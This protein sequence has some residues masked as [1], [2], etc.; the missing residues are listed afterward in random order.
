MP[1]D[2]E[3]CLLLRLSLSVL[4]QGV[5]VSVYVCVC[6]CVT[7]AIRH[8]DDDSSIHIQCKSQFFPFNLLI[9]D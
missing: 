8:D 1:A 9:C 7:D 2:L 3:E 4:S 6:G 5:Y